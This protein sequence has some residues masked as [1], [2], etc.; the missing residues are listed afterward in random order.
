MKK[1]QPKNKKIAKNTVNYVLYEEADFLKDCPN[2]KFIPTTLPAVKRIIAIGDIHGDLNLAIR[3]FKLAKLIDDN[4]NWIAEPADTIVV[5]VGD[6]IDSCR[7]IP[8]V[9][10]CQTTKYPDDKAEDMDVINFFDD[11]H[12]KASIKGGAVYSLLG[13]HELMNSQGIFKYVS[14]E[15]YYNFAYTDHTTG[16]VYEGPDG[17]K[18][19]FKPGSP[20]ASK[21]ACT[22]PSVLIVGSTMFVHAGVL[23]VLANKLDY[24]GFDGNTK[25]KYLN[26]V[27]RKWLLHK[28]SNKNDKEN[29]H[30]IIND[31]TLSPFWTRIYGSIPI[32]T[33]L[34]SNEC[35]T[36]VKKALEVYKVGQLV[37]GHTPQLFTNKDGING[38]CYET[39]GKKKLYRVDGGFSRAFRVLDNHNLVQ[40]LEIIDDKEFNI[41]TDT[42]IQ[43]YVK[44]MNIGIDEQQ[45][46]KI[47]EFYSQNRPSKKF[48]KSKKRIY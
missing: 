26:A 8:N 29:K 18:R 31:S 12:S 43:E 48:K 32:N 14:Y 38:T 30:M 16:E 20:L 3:S 1:D 45:M 7:P 42:S 35:F 41:I 22:R 33:D 46:N 9:Y 40:I 4:N 13:N 28:L 11:M 5:Q 47:S 24:L 2:Y 36:S 44:P 23:P 10:E 15:N 27:V 19:A 39:D 25:I 6:Q 21:L 34:N 37:V 17:R